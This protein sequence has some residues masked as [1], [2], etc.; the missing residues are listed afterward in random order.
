M[1]KRQLTRRQA[2]RI[3][4]IQQ[5][6]LERA[7]RKQQHEL[8]DTGN[9]QLGPAQ[10]GLVVA[11]YGATLDIESATGACYRC[12]VRQNLGNLVVGDRV[13]WQ[14]IDESSGVITALVPRDNQLAR[15][16]KLGILKPIAANIDQLLIVTAPLPAYSTELIDQYLAAAELSHITPVLLFNK[17]DLLDEASRESL[18]D[19]LE[20]YR[21]IGYSLIQASTKTE[22]GLDELHE[23]LKGKTSVFVG[24]SGVG[25]SSLVRT[26]LPGVEIAIGELS[27]GSGLGQHT[28]SASRLYHLPHGGAIIDSP[29]VREFRLW[30]EE[31]ERLIEGFIE[32]LPHLGH[33]RFRDCRH[34]NEPGCAILKAVEQG[35]ISRQR[36]KNFYRIR[37]SLEQTR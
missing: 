34:D 2:W 4:K 5:E 37:Q 17:I 30:Q 21:S 8:N 31:A 6:R 29:G 33:C 3:E 13:I 12:V 26:L 16:D 28:T 20:V 11:N 32:F 24:Q 36:L 23:I 35:A 18:A 10:Q 19:D 15:P 14:V 9:E 7:Q 27:E 25:K 22:H 1:A